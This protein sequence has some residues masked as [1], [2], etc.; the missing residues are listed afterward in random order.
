MKRL[1]NNAKLD[2]LKPWHIIGFITLAWAFSL[3]LLGRFSTNVFGQIA[4]PEVFKTIDIPKLLS[5][6]FNWDA[7]WYYSIAK[8]GY[9]KTITPIYAFFPLFPIMVRLI[10]KLGLNIVISGF[11]IN[12]VATFFSLLGLY[13]L[14]LEFFD[15]K[16]AWLTVFLFMAFPM[17]FFM[18]AFY[19]EALFCA[20]SFW[21]IYFTRKRFWAYASILAMFCSATRLIGLLVGLVVVIEYFQSKKFKLKNVDTQ[22][23]WL[24]LAPIGLLA[25]SVFAH[26]QTGDYLAMLKAYKVGEWSYQSFQ[27]NF[28]LTLYKQSA[29]VWHN[30]DILTLIPLVCFFGF[31]IITI[32]TIQ[33]LP[34]S[35]SIYTLLSLLIF[36]LNSNVVSVNRYVLPLFSVYIGVAMLL[37]NRTEFI[38]LFIVVMAIAQGV[39]FTVFA[40]GFWI[41]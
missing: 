14:S 29:L 38:Q 4:Q 12:L 33:R 3:I 16:K 36:I 39:F 13:K 6:S 25:Y 28:L 17:S 18:F 23:W 37:K 35:Y 7:G 32:L 20:L 24:S 22:V 19:T 5:F 26:T 31:F 1:L 11:L 30:G 34:L 21:A 41:G 2:N 9:S 8:L 15:N 27:P 10:S 40:N